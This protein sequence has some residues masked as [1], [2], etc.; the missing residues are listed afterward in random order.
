M[1]ND[2]KVYIGESGNGKGTFA[3]QLIKKG[4]E[5]IEFNGPILKLKD[6]PS[7]YDAVEDHYVQIGDGLYMGPSGKEDDLINHSCNPNSGLIMNSGKVVLIAIKDI[8][9]GEEII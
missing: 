3:K 5:I 2:D 7:P 8:Y 6:L 9:Q 4:E 1:G